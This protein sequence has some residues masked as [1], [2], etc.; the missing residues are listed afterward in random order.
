[1]K[2]QVCLNYTPKMWF[3]SYANFDDVFL[4]TIIDPN[5]KDSRGRNAL[6]AACSA[7]SGID[8]TEMV[9]MLIDR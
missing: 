5:K 2:E 7:P 3:S 4:R 1:M 6:H 8:I 9:K